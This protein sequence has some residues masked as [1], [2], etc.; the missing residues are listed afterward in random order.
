MKMLAINHDVEDYEKWKK[1]F[2]QFP[3]GKD[4]ATFHRVNRNVE[5]PN[6]ITVVAGFETVEAARAFA[7]DPKLKEA[8]GEAGVKGAPRIELFD[9]VEAVTY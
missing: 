5:N 9:E 2:D 7:H 3:P 6:N 8:M 1:V 4:G